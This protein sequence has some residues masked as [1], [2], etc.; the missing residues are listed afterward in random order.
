MQMQAGHV[1]DAGVMTIDGYLDEPIWMAAKGYMLEQTQANKKI[2]LQPIE[3]GTVRLLWSSEYLFIGVDLSDS[4][5]VQE[6]DRDQQHHYRTGD[7]IEV[8][9]KPAE[10]PFYWE[11][12]AAPNDSATA[13]FYP[14]RGRLGLPSN[15]DYQSR[16]RVAVQLNGTLN[17]WRD[18]D[19]GWSAEVVIPRS[20]L[21]AH[22]IPFDPGQS[23]RILIGRYN[24]SA[25]LTDR[26]LTMYP[27]LPRATFHRYEYWARLE[28]HEEASN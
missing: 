16:V 17:D 26:E 22:G 13:F 8:F 1:S 7:V 5:V 18:R 6:D 4:D 25:F 11:F 24:Y 12:Y 15:L 3:G 10:A 2:G 27:P 23:W 21:T 20:E 19:V 9:L 28:F 14:G